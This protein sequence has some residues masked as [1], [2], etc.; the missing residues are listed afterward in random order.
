[1]DRFQSTGFSRRL[2]LMGAS[3]LALSG[4]L[5]VSPTAY[6][7]SKPPAAGVVEEVIV[8]GSR[9]ITNGNNSPTPV[10]VSTAED[11]LKAQ[12]AGVIQGLNALPALIGSVNSTSSNQQGGYNLLNLRGVGFLRG[13]FLYD[14]RRIGPTQGATG[15][16][17]GSVDLDVIPQLLLK[18]VDVVTGGASAVYGSDAVSGVVN[19]ITDNNFNGIKANASYG[20][21]TYSDDRKLNLGVAAGR[22]LFGGRGHVE[23]SFEHYDAPGV[24]G[25]EARSATAGDYMVQ[26]SSPSALAAGFAQGTV[27]NPLIL[28]SGSVLSTATYGG[29]INSGPLAN[30]MFAQQRVLS[31]FV[32]GAPTGTGGVQI[33]GS[34]AKYTRST[35]VAAQRNDRFFARFDYAFSDAVHGYV[36]GNSSQ[37]SDGYTGQNVFLNR[38]TLGYNN[39]FLQGVTSPVAIPTTGTFTFS[40][41]EEGLPNYQFQ[42]HEYYYVAAAGLDGTLGKYKWN[43]DFQHTDSNFHLRANTNV[44]AGRLYA[45]LNAVVNPANGQIV[46]NAAL[47]NPATY[48]GCVPLN[49]F[50]PGAESAAAIAYVERASHSVTRNTNDEVTA[51]IAGSPF[52]TRAGAVNMAVSG[53]FRRLTYGV[54]SDSSALTPVDCV[55]I[56]FNCTSSTTMNLTN[57]IT[58]LNTVDET[59]GEVAVEADIPILS[60]LS[61]ADQF[62]INAAARYTN[63]STSG[64]VVTWKI[65]GTWRINDQLTLRATRSRDI[66]A[67]SLSDLYNPPTPLPKN[68]SDFLTGQSGLVLDYSEGN[69][70][71]QPERADTSTAG[72]V[73]RPAAISGL[74]LAIDAYRILINDALGSIDASAPST[75][76][77][78]RASG[79]ASPVCALYTRPFPYSNTTPANYPTR[80]ATQS[81][82]IAAVDTYGAD[83]EVNYATNLASRPLSA[84]VLF[85]WQPHLYY[86]NGPLGIVDV[87]GAADGVT[88]LPATSSLKLIANATYQITDKLSL[89]LQERWRG[90]LRQNGSKSIYYAIGKL[91]SVA[92]TD[93]TATYSVTRTLTA[94]FNVQNLFNKAP[95]PWASSGATLQMNYLGGYAASDDL[96][97]RYYTLGFRLKM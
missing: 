13:L 42:S 24:A 19:F 7:Q 1:M 93:F 11:L 87:G 31:P 4:A 83:F 43:L 37:Y 81:L 29:M 16:F 48:G 28:T 2:A 90:P 58:P 63:Y 96:E 88:G 20:I 69:A 64:S 92:Y 5:A 77:T 3:A 66:R 72:V 60:G 41:M 35:I 39:P 50:G 53:D 45:A 85:T 84:R 47:V 51:T 80:L 97:G 95:P 46:C 70:N 40:K 86:D 33:G 68:Y 75:A 10:T 78:C 59:V 32:N 54:V 30:L 52:S 74:S 21:S 62:N 38:V 8:T 56:Q 12:P 79:G 57:L 82:N 73:W 76:A 55:G 6:A 61:F 44:N 34:G 91:E 18:R 27:Q 22:E 67:P 49:L 65:G 14:G 23:A 71:L 25:R 89:F 17:T 94:Y 36:Q 15:L 26:G 9:V